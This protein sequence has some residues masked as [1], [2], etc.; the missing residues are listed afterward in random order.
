M[1]GP[2]HRIR[3]LLIETIRSLSIKIE[4]VLLAKSARQLFE[5][6]TV[7]NLKQAFAEI[8]KKPDLILMEID[9][10]D[11]PE[12]SQLTRLRTHARRVPHV[13]LLAGR[14]QPAALKVLQ[15]GAQSYLLENQ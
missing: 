9:P 1:Q 15:A 13:A 4:D 5:T 14:H 6:V 12:F 2:S 7:P 10:H 8:E 11:D 3:I